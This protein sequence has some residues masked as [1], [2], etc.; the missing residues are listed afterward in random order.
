MSLDVYLISEDATHK[1][2]ANR[3]FIRENGKTK[4]ITREEWD[5][6]N[7]G[8]TPV[9]LIDQEAEDDKVYHDNITHNLGEMAIQAELYNALW[10]PDELGVEKAYDLLFSL[11]MGLEKLRNNPEHFKTFNPKNGW[12]DYEGLV[13][14][15]A[16]YLAACCRYPRATVRVSR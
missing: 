4:G 6:R 15:T 10:R 9:M 5:K 14:F 11:A 13:E 12:G 16:N 8:V 1:V 7:P 2:P 3:I